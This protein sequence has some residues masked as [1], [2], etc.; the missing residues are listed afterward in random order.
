MLPN[1]DFL[2]RPE[3]ENLTTQVLGEWNIFQ[4]IY[5]TTIMLIMR[6]PE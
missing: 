2:N 1:E 5:F 6:T 3:Q 4:V